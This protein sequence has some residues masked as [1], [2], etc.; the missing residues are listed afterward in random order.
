MK[1]NSEYLKNGQR[2]REIREA[3]DVT[4][5]D[6]A[7]M[8]GIASRTLQGAELG[9]QTI[10]RKVLKR[11]EELVAS[12][13]EIPAEV[14]KSAPV[15]EAAKGGS[16]G[17]ARDDNELLLLRLYRRLGAMRRIKLI[18]ALDDEVQVKNG[19]ASG[20]VEDGGEAGHCVGKAC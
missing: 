5:D 6:F 18:A 4:R 10:S 15:A 13:S 12:R 1:K 20:A 3:L 9:S 14:A 7:R 17:V 16:E 2:L 19:S 8:L 11:A